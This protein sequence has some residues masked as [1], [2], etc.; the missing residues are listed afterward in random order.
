MRDFFDSPSMVIGR[1]SNL[2]FTQDY[3]G[4]ILVNMLMGREV[5]DQEKEYIYISCG[6]GEGRHELVMR[7]V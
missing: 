6:S 7:A 1:G 2:L 5:I 3:Q 4:T